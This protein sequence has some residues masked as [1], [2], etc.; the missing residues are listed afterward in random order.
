MRR[1]LT[2]YSISLAALAGALARGPALSAQASVGSPIRITIARPRLLIS[3]HDPFSGFPILRARLA[4]GCREFRS[5]KF[6]DDIAGSDLCSFLDLD[7]CELAADFG[8]DADL[9]RAHDAD[10]GG[11]GSGPPQPITTGCRREEK[12]EGDEKTTPTASHAPASA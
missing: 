6:S 3:E 12:C 11:R 4:N 7:G 10:D 9:G 2:A 5:G 1:P 8:G